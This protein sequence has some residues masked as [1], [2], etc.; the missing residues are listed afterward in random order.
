M[1]LN[2][3]RKKKTNKFMIL[4]LSNYQSKNIVDKIVELNLKKLDYFSLKIIFA[5]N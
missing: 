2:G 4:P 5:K 1:K 3:F